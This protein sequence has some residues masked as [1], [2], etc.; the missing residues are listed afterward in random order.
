MISLRLLL[1]LYLYPAHYFRDINT[2][3]PKLKK[4]HVIV[5]TPTQGAVRNPSTKASHGE[6]VYK[7]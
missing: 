6:P 2:Y 7:I 3:F 1:Q 4:R 5:T